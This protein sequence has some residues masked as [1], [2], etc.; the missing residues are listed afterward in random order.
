MAKLVTRISTTTQKGRQVD[1][2]DL[3]E[4]D[5]FVNGDDDAL[6]VALCALDCETS[7]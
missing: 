2:L 1:T 7:C 6:V 4:V 3:V 5:T